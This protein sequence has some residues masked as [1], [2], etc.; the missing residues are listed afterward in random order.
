MIQRLIVWRGSCRRIPVLLV[1][2]ALAFALGLVA[3]DPLTA[4]LGPEATDAQRAAAAQELGLGDPLPVRYLGFLWHALQAAIS[5]SVP[6]ST[7]RSAR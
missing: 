4:A 2:A 1:V 6:G 5:A 3:G 7:G